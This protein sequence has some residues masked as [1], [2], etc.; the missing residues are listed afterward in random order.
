MAQDKIYASPRERIIPFEFNEQVAGVF[1][2]M[3]ERSVPLYRE[4]LLRQAQL[5]AR[6]YQP[7]TRIYDLG[8]SNGNF[9]MAL[10]AAMAGRPFRMVAVDTSQPMLDAYR[11]RL[12]ERPEAA[13]VSLAAE[14]IRSLPLENAS[15]VV[16]NLTLQFL[17]VPDRDTLI[18]RI[19]SALAPGGILLLTEKITQ[20]NP[21]LAQ[22]QQEFYHCFKR[23]NGYSELEISQKREA[24]ENVLI[25]ETL[26][27]HCERLG[28]AGFGP[29]EVWLKWFNFAAL[30]ALRES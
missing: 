11:R 17:P 19:H 2:D 7:G 16:V 24:L 6:F 23:D 18:R 21:T 29:V 30:V 28:R 3:L 10:C 25:P 27:V 1:D 4:T 22:L 9:G 20:Q 13:L 8:C 15:V 12:A 5:A 14:D 26:E